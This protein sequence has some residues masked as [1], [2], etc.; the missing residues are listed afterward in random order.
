MLNKVSLLVI[1]NDS[2]GYHILDLEINT[3]SVKFFN[4]P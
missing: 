3:L 1:Q 4:V 2:T